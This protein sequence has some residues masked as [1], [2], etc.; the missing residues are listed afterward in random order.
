MTGDPTDTPNRRRVLRAIGTTAVVAGLAGCSGDGGDGD[1][2]EGGDGDG[3]VDGNETPDGDET[4]GATSEDGDEPT[5]E[6]PFETRV[7][8][9]LSES[10]TYTFD[11]QAGARV[12]VSVDSADGTTTLV[13][14]SR[15]GNFLLNDGTDS[16][17][18][19]VVEIP[20]SGEY[21]F[22]ITPNEEA[23]ATIAVAEG[24]GEGNSE[25]DGSQS[26]GCAGLTE[27]GYSRYDESES[28]FVGTF[29]YPG[30]VS[31]TATVNNTHSLTIRRHVGDQEAFD[32]L[33]A[34]DLVGTDSPTDIQLGNGQG[35]EQVDE[36]DFGGESVPL[37]RAA[38]EAAGDDEA[39]YYN[40]YPYYIAG[41]PHEGSDGKQ[42][43]RMSVRATV[44]YADN[45]EATDCGDVFDEVARRMMESLEPNEDTTVEEAGT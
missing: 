23:S 42:Y 5:T 24:S 44:Q 18:T 20:E 11:L 12:R 33:P 19:W 45:L 37:I 17:D 28:P 3:D 22:E 2:D 40:K 21:R 26:G 16:S 25:E 39:R 15:S 6:D 27:G 14:A 29:E 36:I 41:L 32:I 10:K 31:A 4:D 7:D 13:F 35:L 38:P 9:Q 43:Y 8:E 30:N 34:Q 1:D